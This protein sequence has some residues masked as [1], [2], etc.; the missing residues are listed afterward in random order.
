[1]TSQNLSY[2]QI[3]LN[4]IEKSTKILKLSLSFKIS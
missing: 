3:K 2:V 1:M 4:D